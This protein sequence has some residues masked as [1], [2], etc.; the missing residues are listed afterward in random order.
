MN[1]PT[2]DDNGFIRGLA[3]TGVNT[4]EELCQILAICYNE[5]LEDIRRTRAKVF[6]HCND[7]VYD[8]GSS[9][10]FMYNWGRASKND[11]I[12]IPYKD[13]YSHYVTKLTLNI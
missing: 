5:P 13:F 2:R 11:L 3:V 8:S 1:L 7:I 10:S 9:I 4:A 6:V 12:Y